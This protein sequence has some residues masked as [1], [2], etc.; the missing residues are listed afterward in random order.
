MRKI[1]AIL[2]LSV[3]AVSLMGAIP[4]GQEARQDDYLLKLKNPEFAVRAKAV[5]AIYKLKASDRDAN[6]I[7]QLIETYKMEIE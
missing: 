7:N 4:S 5:N 3:W 6:L 1:P 2:I